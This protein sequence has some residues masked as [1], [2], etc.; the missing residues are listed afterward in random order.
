MEEKPKLTIE[1]FQGASS[2]DELLEIISKKK[3]FL[4]KK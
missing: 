1:D 3:M 4:L 2:S